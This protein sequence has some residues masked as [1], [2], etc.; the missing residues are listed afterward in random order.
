[1][2][3]FTKSG[4]NGSRAGQTLEIHMKN[5]KPRQ[6]AEGRPDVLPY[7]SAAAFPRYT[8]GTAISQ[9]RKTTRSVSIVAEELSR[10]LSVARDSLPRKGGGGVHCRFFP[11]TT[12]PSR[13]HHRHRKQR[14]CSDTLTPAFSDSSESEDIVKW[15]GFYVVLLHNRVA[16]RSVRLLDCSAAL[17]A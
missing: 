9:P 2:I 5:E 11:A 3:Q 10:R 13:S 1:M 15:R 17:S 14:P 7:R 6:V 8:V 16:C 12:S 4:M